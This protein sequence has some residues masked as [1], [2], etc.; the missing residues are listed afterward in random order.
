MANSTGKFSTSVKLGKYLIAKPAIL[1]KLPAIKP[2]LIVNAIL[3]I[4]AI[5][6]T[7]VN[8][9]AGK[10]VNVK[11]VLHPAPKSP[12]AKIKVRDLKR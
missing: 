1:V 12:I 7:Y 11:Y 3:T 2:M 4:Y 9:A 10:F 5:L 8:Q 6:A